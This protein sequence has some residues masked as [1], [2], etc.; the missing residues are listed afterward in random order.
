MQ[1]EILFPHGRAG[2]V[3]W[4]LVTESRMIMT[5]IMS[6]GRQEFTPRLFVFVPQHE[7]LSALDQIAPGG[8]LSQSSLKERTPIPRSHRNI[9]IGK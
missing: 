7:Q 6:L 2:K 5:F 4:G 1:A 3:Y 9:P 8:V